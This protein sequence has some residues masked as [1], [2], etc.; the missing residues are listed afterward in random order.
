MPAFTISNETET[1]S[2]ADLQ[3]K[4]ALIIFFSTTCGDCRQALPEMDRLYT[5]YLNHPSVRVLLIARGQTEKEVRAYL[6]TT[7]YDPDFFTDPD[8]KVYSLFADN[9]IPRLFL[10]GKDGKILLTQTEYVD[11]EEVMDI[12][13]QFRSSK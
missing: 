1:V 13:K 3:N 5:T 6:D 11:S 9:T 7:Q 10:S 2:T 8:K 4:M 12:I